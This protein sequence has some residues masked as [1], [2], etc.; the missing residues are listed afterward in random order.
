MLY[1]VIYRLMHDY[2]IFF[3]KASRLKEIRD[4][5]A[6]SMVYTS[7]SKTAVKFHDKHPPQSENIF[8]DVVLI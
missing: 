5:K 6:M 1:S 2:I 3:L 8:T 7:I 4:G